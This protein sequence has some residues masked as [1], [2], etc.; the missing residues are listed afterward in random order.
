MM[1]QFI[2]FLFDCHDP[3][4]F[5]LHQFLQILYVIVYV[6]LRLVH[7]VEKYHFLLYMVTE[8]LFGEI[9]HLIDVLSVAVNDFLFFVEDHLDEFFVL[10]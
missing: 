1:R 3:F 5:G 9:N 6:R 2:D 8:N 10:L 4:D 7:L